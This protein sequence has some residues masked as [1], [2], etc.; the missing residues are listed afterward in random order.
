[1]DNSEMG[2]Y[3]NI[4]CHTV[5]DNSELDNVTGEPYFTSGNSGDNDN[6]SNLTSKLIGGTPPGCVQAS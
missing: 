4:L 1:M 3:D 6:V 5:H 2:G